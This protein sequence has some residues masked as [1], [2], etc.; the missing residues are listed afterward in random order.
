MSADEMDRVLD[1]ERRSG[2]DKRLHRVAIDEV[3]DGAMIADHDRAFA[4]RAGTLRE[5][6]FEGYGDAR[7]MPV[8]RMVD[9]LTPP[10]ICAAL[11]RG[12]RPRWHASVTLG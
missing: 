7:P 12:Y 9:L 5:W 10:S 8:S 4:M 6:S 11:K 1:R 3:P 2:R